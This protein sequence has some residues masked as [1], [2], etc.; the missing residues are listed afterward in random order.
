[1]TVKELIKMGLIS[2][3]NKIS[4]INNNSLMGRNGIPRE[5]GSMDAC[6]IPN[7]SFEI[8]KDGTYNFTYTNDY[9]VYNKVKN[10]KFLY[11]WTDTNIVE[12]PIDNPIF[13]ALDYRG[14]DMKKI[15]NNEAIIQDQD[16]NAENL[17]KIPMN[18]EVEVVGNV[19]D[20]KFIVARYHG[21]NCIL[22]VEDLRDYDR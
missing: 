5:L 20:G 4:F 7:V 18:E 19:I 3:G 22:K 14:E 12:D 10:A 21:K 15:T 6:M 13:F 9:Y 16:L 11:M 1:M 2:R 8:R 17:K